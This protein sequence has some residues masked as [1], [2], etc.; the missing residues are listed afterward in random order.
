MANTQVLS[1]RRSPA[2]DYT[3]HMVAGSGRGASLSEIPFQTQVSIR[4]E[5]GSEAARAVTHLLGAELPEKVGQVVATKQ[6]TEGHILWLGP[7]DFLLVTGDEATTNISPADLSAQLAQ[8]IGTNPGQAVD[9]TGNRTVLELSGSASFEVLC[10]M[11]EVDLH[12]SVFEAN[13]A[14]LTVMAG[15]GV[16]VWKRSE[17]TWWIM[18][19]SSFAPHTVAWLLDAMREYNN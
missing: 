18:P 10:K 6:P 7:D 5:L 16:I 1:Y 12:P 19:R 14:I 13:T 17:D 11:V 4:A 15:S 2:A 9:L 8:A 3:E